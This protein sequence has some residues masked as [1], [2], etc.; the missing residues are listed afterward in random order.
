MNTTKVKLIKEWNQ[1]QFKQVEKAITKHFK[2]KVIKTHEN[3]FYE[4]KT[5]KG[6][7]QVL[8]L[9]YTSTGLFACYGVCNVA[10]YFDA[11]DL[12][13]YCYFAIG[14][15]GTIYTIIQDSEENELCIKL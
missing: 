11:D 7:D 10:A 14:E 8:G 1:L 13:Q 5:F 6:I 12:F 4:F 3:K 9:A 15:D 2:G